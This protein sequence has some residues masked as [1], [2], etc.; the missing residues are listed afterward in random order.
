MKQCCKV[1]S[2]YL[3]PGKEHPVLIIITVSIRVAI[4]LLT[5]LLV[6]FVIFFSHIRQKQIV[7]LPISPLSLYPLSLLLVRFFARL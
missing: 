3:P 5:S 1:L 7:I 6:P 4:S 2:R